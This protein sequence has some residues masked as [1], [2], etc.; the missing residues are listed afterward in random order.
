LSTLAVEPASS[1]LIGL[2]ESFDPRSKWRVVDSS[3]SYRREVSLA[4]GGAVSP[5]PLT[6]RKM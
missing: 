5:P 1:K 3:R 4:L 6:G 2:Q